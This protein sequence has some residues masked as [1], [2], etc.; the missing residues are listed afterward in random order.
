M[1]L[2]NSYITYLNGKIVNKC[3]DG[4]PYS[5]EARQTNHMTRLSSTIELSVCYLSLGVL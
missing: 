5:D 1:K 3:G 4:H 2:K